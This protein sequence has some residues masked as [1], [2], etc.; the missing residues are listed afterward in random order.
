MGDRRWPVNLHFNE[1]G[2]VF[3]EPEDT[4]ETFECKKGVW[5]SQEE[6]EELE[7][8]RRSLHSLGIGTKRPPEEV[9]EHF[10][11]LIDEDAASGTG[12]AT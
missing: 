7:G 3:H 9:F 1:A 6:S 8:C 11:R 10:R 5:Y 2:A 12:G 4:C